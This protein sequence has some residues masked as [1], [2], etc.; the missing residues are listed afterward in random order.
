MGV[1]TRLFT[2]NDYNYSLIFTIQGVEVEA[3]YSND[4]NNTIESY[5]ITTGYDNLQ[6]ETQRDFS[7]SF[8]ELLNNID[9]ISSYNQ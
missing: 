7:Y 9:R 8:P 3:D 4:D 6:Q 2:P 1:E 5:S